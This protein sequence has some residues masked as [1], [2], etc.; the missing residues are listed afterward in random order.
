MTKA[1][2]MAAARETLQKLS[3]AQAPADTFG[4]IKHWNSIYTDYVHKHHSSD[5]IKR[6]AIIEYLEEQI[7]H[8]PIGKFVAKTLKI[9]VGL[10]T[11]VPLVLSPMFAAIEQLFETT[12]TAS[13]FEELQELN[14]SVQRAA[15]DSLTR[16]AGFDWYR[17]F[18]EALLKEIARGKEQC[19]CVLPRLP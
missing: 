14:A 16:M 6:D 1:D 9:L 10:I 4:A 3:R 11:E 18:R 8:E 7:E 2:L 5:S 15:H 19:P 12:S 17:G 13:D